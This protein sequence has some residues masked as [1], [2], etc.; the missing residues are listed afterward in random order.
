MRADWMKVII[1]VARLPLRSDPANNQ[2]ER[3]SAQGRIRFPTWLLSM[4]KGLPAELEYLHCFEHRNSM[5]GLGL[6]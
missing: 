1:A 2:V 4:G 6:A 3:P 5:L